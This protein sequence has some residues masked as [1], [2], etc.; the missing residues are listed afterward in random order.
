MSKCVLLSYMYVHVDALKN[1]C[2]WC[3]YSAPIASSPVLHAEKW[4]IEKLG[5]A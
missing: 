3:Y 1:S 2:L 5:E 4:N